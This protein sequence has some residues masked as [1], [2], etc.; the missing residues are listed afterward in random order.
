MARPEA[1]A[2]IRQD[3]D[4]HRRELREAFDELRAAARSWAD[5]GDPVRTHPAAWLLGAMAIG[6]WF[7]WRR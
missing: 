5:P 6:M 4:V 3:M 7:G 1:V 2:Q